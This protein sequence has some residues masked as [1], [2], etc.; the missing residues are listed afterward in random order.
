M[1]ATGNAPESGE[2]ILATLFASKA[3]AT[4][5]RV[6]AIDPRRPYYQRQIET[7]TGLAIR[8]VQREL[9]RLSTLGL[10][11]RHVEG[12]RTYYRVDPQ[13]PLF[14]ELQAMV[15]KTAEPVDRLRATIAMAEGVRLAFLS[16][17]GD[18]VLVVTS[19]PVSSALAVSDPFQ[20]ETVT[21]E[22]FL[23][24]LSERRETLDPFLRRGAD[25]LGRRDD[26]LWRRIEVAGY[27]VKKGK[28]VV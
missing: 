16:E 4:V 26:V 3:R 14:A 18:R 27:Q 22:E 23:A 11:Y 1:V 15:L 2:P 28:G 25:L 5:L 20:V 7:A 6:F 10:L 12:N 21:T 17:T 8:A 19:G 24:A 9:E 13:F